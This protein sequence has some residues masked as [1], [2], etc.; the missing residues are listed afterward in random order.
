MAEFDESKHPR[1]EQGKFTNGNGA[2]EYRQ[3][4]P[5]E[6]ISGKLIPEKAYGFANKQRKHTKDHVAHAQEMG[7]KNQ[8]DYEKAAC[9]FFN[10]DKG[11]LYFEP[12]RS[13]FYRYDEKSQRMAVSSN[14][15]I[16]TF[17]FY[18]KKKFEK[19]RKQEGLNDL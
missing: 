7:F 8:D 4:T 2:T 16:H 17:L 9:E 11:K 18:D 12:R 19:V 14:G 13:R 3:N 10:G 6:Q 5:Y 15:I 1:D